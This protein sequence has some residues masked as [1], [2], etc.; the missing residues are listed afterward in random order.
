MAKTDTENAPSS[1]PKRLRLFVAGEGGFTTHQLP[2]SGEV[3]LGRDPACG[4]VVDDGSVAPRH[5]VLSMGP[6]VRIDDLGS[7]LPTSVGEE[8]VEAGHPI[9]L[10]PGDIL[11]LGGVIAMV[12]GRGAAPPRRIL[13][14]GY[15]E[16]RLE[17]ECNRAARFHST[18]ALLRIACDPACPPAVI[19]EV[20]AS[21]V[22]LVDIVA[23]DGPSDYEVLLLDTPPDDV[24]LVVSRLEAQLGERGG[25]PR[26]SVATYPR[27]GRSTDA[28]LARASGEPVVRT[29]PEATPAPGAMQD[30]YQMVERIASSD[31]SVI[32]FGETGV[33]KERLAEAVH[34]NSR[35]APLPFLRLNCAALTETLLESELFGHEKGA[36]TGAAAAKAGLLESANGGSVFL[37]EVG[38]MPMPTQVK[39]LRVIEEHKV[40]RVGAI[41]TTEIDVRFVAAT[42]RDLELEVQRGNFRKDLYF[43]LNGVSVFVPP[44]RERVEEIE[45]LSRLLI[46]EA[47]KR[48]GRTQEPE[49]TAETLAFLLQYPWPGNIRELRNVLE[50]AVLLCTGSRLEL[51]HLPGEKMSS[52]FATRRLEYGPPAVPTPLPPVAM[53]TPIPPTLLRAPLAP[54]D[55]REQLAQAERQRIID[56]LSRCAGNQTEA[57]VSL[58]ISRRT[59][60]KR[61]ATFNIPRP[62][63]R[64]GTET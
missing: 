11:H 37:D 55:L 64:Q 13:P 4:V 3:T 7:G 58:G 25:K 18:F 32:I 27:D 34:K 45:G 46:A 59:L 23:A 62:R 22:R 36:F 56:A 52:H 44:L 24:R 49:L 47:S 30:L 2:E 17:E 60:V 6:P 54:A 8:R 40:R 10:A 50:R 14:H 53:P 61:L 63:K 39:L 19:E 48:M 41:K 9:E 43:R 20:L 38:D 51:S 31:I 12:E 57:A 33:G 16:L 15:F 29:A 1:Q 21:A 5:A 28:L 42:N 26:I 35:R